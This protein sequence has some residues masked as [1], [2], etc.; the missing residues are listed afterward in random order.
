MHAKFRT[1]IYHFRFQGE[2]YEVLALEFWDVD[3][4]RIL[5]VKELT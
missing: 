5:A 2:V 4:W 3:F 1:H